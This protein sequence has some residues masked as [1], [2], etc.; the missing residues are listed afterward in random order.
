MDDIIEER[1]LIDAVTDERGTIPRWWERRES[2]LCG[3]T[4][5]GIE[6]DSELVSS[7]GCG[8]TLYPHEDHTRTEIA[9][10]KSAAR[11][12]RDVVVFYVKRVPK[13]WYGAEHAPDNPPVNGWVDAINWIVTNHQWRR[14]IPETGEL[15]PENRRGGIKVDAFTAGA[16]KA[17]YDGLNEKN[18]Q[19]FR[20]MDVRVAA[21]IAFSLVK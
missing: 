20:G 9:D 4:F 7:Q 3:E 14:V 8:I 11:N 13:S 10:A 21:H 12:K 5:A 16:L 19:K 1:D 6:F 17:V 18:K 15:V 2:L